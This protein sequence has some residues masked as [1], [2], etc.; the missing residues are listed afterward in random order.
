MVQPQATSLPEGRTVS[1]N[2]SDVLPLVTMR[3]SKSDGA[4]Q[5]SLALI[6][7]VVHHDELIA[8]KAN[9]MALPVLRRGTGKALLTS[10]LSTGS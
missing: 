1:V 4:H 8:Q 7:A 9:A 6:D 3:N 10:F 5:N 2:S